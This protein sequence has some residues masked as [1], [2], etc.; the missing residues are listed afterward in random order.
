VTFLFTD[1]EGSTRIWQLDET[2]MRAAVRRHD[3][4]VRAAV[5]G[6]GGAVFA[7]LGDGFAAAF[8]SASGA[9]GAAKQAQEK[10][11][12]EAWPTAEPVRVL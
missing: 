2:R 9:L 1:I 6:N 4:L 11:A 10:L 3:E 12:S 8:A 5:T 7:T